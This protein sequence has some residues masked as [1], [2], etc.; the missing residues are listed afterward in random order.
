MIQPRRVL[1]RLSRYFAGYPRG[2][3]PMLLEVNSVVEQRR[4]LEGLG[5]RVATAI[6]VH[7]RLFDVG[8]RKNL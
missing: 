5:I 7:L 8:N 6:A 3:K 4:E 2:W 1:A